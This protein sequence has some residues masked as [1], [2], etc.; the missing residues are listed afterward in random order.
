MWNRHFQSLLNE[1][2]AENEQYDNEWREYIE[3][4]VKHILREA[5]PDQCPDGVDLSS[6]TSEEIMEKIS[7]LPNG[8][9]PGHD[10]LTYEHIKHGG[11]HL[12]ECITR[13]FNA[14]I[15]HVRIPSGFKQGLLIPLYKGGKKPRCNKN[16]Y[17]GITLLPV[18]NKLFERC[19]HDR[20]SNKLQQMKFPSAL[21]FAGKKVTT[22]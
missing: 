16:S 19:I 21:Q 20:I 5:E 17:R 9:A 7:A 12:I 18:L 3:E 14:I 1:S 8:K 11:N 6:F 13:L 15:K 10:M 4:E 2:Q 22:V